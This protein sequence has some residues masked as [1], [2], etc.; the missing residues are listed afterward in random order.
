MQYRLIVLSAVL[1]SF[2]LACGPG[3]LTPDEVRE[4]L[5]NPKGQVAPEKMNFVVDDF[6]GA[7]R[8]SRA[9]SQANFLKTSESSDG[10][11]AALAAALVA[12]DALDSAMAKA[13]TDDVG[14]FFCAAGL[15]A[16]IATFDDC[17]RGKNCEAEFTLDSCVLR[18]GEDG[19]RDAKGKIIF[20][21][22]QSSTDAFDREELSIEFD[23]FEST[24]T[25]EAEL[26]SFDGIVAVEFTEYSDGLRDEQIF[27]TD[28]VER[29]VTKNHGLFDDG[30]IWESRATV[31]L[32][33]SAQRDGEGGGSA[34][35]EL[36]CFVDDTVDTRDESV[37]ITF[38]TES[39]RIS[40]STSLTDSSLE[41]TGSNGSF[42]CTF[43]TAEESHAEGST[44][45]S[46]NGVCVDE[47]GEE[48]TWRSS[49]NHG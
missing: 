25:N 48:F 9:E 16:S 13:L 6:F 21:R 39:N 33:A 29:T 1:F 23:G 34:K 44:S 8:S 36:L 35:L 46:S 2:V 10:S 32:R 4:H 19:D 47:G 27:S 14:D 5:D 12:N 24:S 22:K 41:V 49:E 20:H 17:G 26:D 11:S 45:Y 30:V 40:E 37:V 3:Y 15:I 7:M 18:I 42:V 28:L 31:A 38:K 43:N